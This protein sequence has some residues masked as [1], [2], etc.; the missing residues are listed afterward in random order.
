MAGGG[1]NRAGLGERFA[2]QG[3]DEGGFTGAG[4]ASDHDSEGVVDAGATRQDVVV[5]LACHGGEQGARGGGA[6]L[7]G[8]V[9]GDGVGGAGGA[10]GFAGF[11]VEREG[12][13]SEQFA[14]CFEL[15]IVGGSHSAIVP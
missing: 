2:E 9:V 12:D 15:R 6:V 10:G 3:V 7:G 8:A 4:G 11:Y 13:S 5:E 14:G 1:S